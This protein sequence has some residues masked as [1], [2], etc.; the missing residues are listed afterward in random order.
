LG[1]IRVFT[2]ATVDLT[3]FGA[4]SKPPVQN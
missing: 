1:Q 3:D 4:W 2:G